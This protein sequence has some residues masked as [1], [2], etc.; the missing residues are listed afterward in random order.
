MV[1]SR[2]NARGAG[3]GRA[4][5]VGRLVAVGGGT[6]EAVG[7]RGGRSWASNEPPPSSPA[8]PLR[9]AILRLAS[10]PAPRLGMRAV[11]EE[12]H[13]KREHCKTVRAAA[14]S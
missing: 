10:E 11:M 9:R 5:V 3:G 12:N 6:R 2:A 7:S 1:D 14:P 4:V 13:T 8:F